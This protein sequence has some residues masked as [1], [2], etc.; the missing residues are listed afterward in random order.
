MN[1]EIEKNSRWVL[2]VF[3]F[4]WTIPIVLALFKLWLTSHLPIMASYGGHD[5]LRYVIM[6]LEIFDFSPPFNYDQYVLMRQPGYPFFIRLSY[7]LGF[8]L[9][10]SQELLYIASGFLLAW[11]LYKYY[12]QK[13]AVIL[14]L[15]L[16]I[17]APNSF[18][19]NRETI[20][21]ALY[22]P[23]IL[24]IVSC[25][26]H[27]INSPP[28][29]NSFIVWS[30]I[31]GG[32]LAWFWNTRAESVWIV[33]TIG[34][35]YTVIIVKI[36]FTSTGKHRFL[37]LKKLGYSIVCLTVP[38]IIVTSSISLATYYKY[39]IFSTTDVTTPGI[40][41]A[42]SSLLRVIPDTQK[43][44]VHVS[45]EARLKIY[46][47][48][49]SFARLSSYLEGEKAQV[50]REASCRDGGICDDYAGA[51]FLWA[52]R[53]AVADAGEYKSAPAT[54]AFYYDI[55]R[56]VN[57]ACQSGSLRCKRKSF[58]S[59]S[60]PNPGINSSEFILFMNGIGSLSKEL[61]ISSL[62][63]LQLSSGEED[64]AHRKVY[65]EK[66][67]R[68]PANFIQERSQLN[69]FKNRLIESV[70]RLYNLFI[71]ALV[72]AAGI[73]LFVEHIFAF[74]PKYKFQKT[75]IPLII[76]YIIFSCICVRVLLFAYL[77]VKSIPPAP[78]YIWPVAPLMLLI[79]AIGVSYLANRLHMIKRLV[80]SK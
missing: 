25:L 56:E 1:A 26:I 41:A 10:F 46:S 9:R 61:L 2:K 16:Y 70:S 15:T 35:V 57:V 44:W 69:T 53:D 36:V 29:Q 40:K 76:A 72:G 49:P 55:A 60:I 4:V 68:E 18:F 80:F 54:E 30:A 50:W 77:S 31:L 20:Q 11:S 7:I 38:V 32:G 45:K 52:L 17:L 37:R 65:Y 12:R 71:P 22:L 3:K 8:S 24:L 13:L 51:W 58:L 6:G 66:I 27:L 47:V 43:H 34:I 59:S 21:E 63:P 75:H 78:R 23:L 64:I 79:V 5:N 19:W 67:T 48:S 62:T 73:G 33:P 42:Y 74:L 14:F 39:G 28:T